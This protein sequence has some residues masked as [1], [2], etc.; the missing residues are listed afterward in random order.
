MKVL[1]TRFETCRR[2]ASDENTQNIYPDLKTVLFAACVGV[3]SEIFQ[4]PSVIV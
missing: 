4:E 1:G 3:Q 2:Y